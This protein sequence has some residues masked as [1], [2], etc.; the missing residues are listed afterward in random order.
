MMRNKLNTRMFGA[1]LAPI[2][3]MRNSTPESVSVLLRPIRSQSQAPSEGPIMQPRI[4][5][6]VANPNCV[7][8]SVNCWRRNNCTP[9]MM[10]RS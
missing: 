1:R 5:L 7:G 6:L 9:E 3:P 10:T 8:V 2:A 4:A